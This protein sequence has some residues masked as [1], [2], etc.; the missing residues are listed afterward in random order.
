MAE[1]FG[2]PQDQGKNGKEKSF[3]E[4]S[5]D[6]DGSE[7]K[8]DISQADLDELRVRDEHAQQ[9][10]PQLESENE[11]MRERI[12]QLEN[13]L[14]SSAKVDEVLERIQNKNSGE[15]KVDPEQVADVV[16]GRLQEKARQEV[17]DRNWETSLGKLLEQY[18]DWDKGNEAIMARSA[19]LGMTVKEASQLARRS[20]DA[21]E[22][23]FLE[24][25]QVTNTQQSMSSVTQRTAVEPAGSPAK[26]DQAYY[27]AMRLSKD[28]RERDRYWS[29]EVQ[30]QM[31]RDLF[32][33]K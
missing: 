27:K 25:K 17:E 32:G 20:P 22:Q 4:E 24:Q 13:D 14:A 16:E 33:A 1:E 15:T 26:R 5:S 12:V 31:R 8:A 11:E 19:Q 23:L 3:K 28:P 18:G 21:F 2:T 6:N 9:H 30:A 29:Q 10:I 7:G